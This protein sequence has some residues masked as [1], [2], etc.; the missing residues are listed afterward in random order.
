VKEVSASHDEM[1]GDRKIGMYINRAVKYTYSVGALL[2]NVF[3]SD[4]DDVDD[5]M[6]FLSPLSGG[7]NISHECII[8]PS[9]VLMR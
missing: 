9:C 3:A 8:T 5:V 1:D 4:D 2:R 6:F 7:C